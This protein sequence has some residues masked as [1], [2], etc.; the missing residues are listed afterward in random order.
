MSMPQPSLRALSAL[1]GFSLGTVSMALRGNPRIAQETRDLILRV[2]TAEGYSPDPL[3]AG[4]M[5]RIRRRSASRP[6][7][8]LAHLVAWDRLTSYYAFRPFREFRD[9]AALRAKEFGYEFEDFLLDEVDM[10][11]RRLSDILRTRAIPGVLI[12]PVQYPGVVNTRPASEPWIDLEF[13]SYATIGYTLSRPH[14][15][16]TVHDHAGALELACAQLASRGYKRTALVLNE[17][18][19]QRV[20]G[21]WLAGWVCAQPD[22]HKAPRPL[23]AADLNDPVVFD[24]WFTREKPDAIV[25]CDWD[26]VSVHLDRLQLRIPADLGLVDLQWPSPGRRRAAIDQCNH[27]VGAAAI[28]IILAQI[29]RHERGQPAVS[30]TVLIPG[31]WVEGPSVRPPSG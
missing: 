24:R 23:I 12:A 3:L 26:A 5:N 4:R 13:T 27:A 17:L 22:L 19:H 28:D 2:A 8:K 10:H 18:M 15:S 25:T 20:R 31:R 29:G 9:G 11:P 6:A 14:I 1:T 21:R 16:R 30:K 7:I